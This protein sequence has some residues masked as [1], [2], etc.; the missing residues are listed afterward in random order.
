MSAALG[1]EFDKCVSTIVLLL[2]PCGGVKKSKKYKNNK[3]ARF[4]HAVTTKLLI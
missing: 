4:Q 2:F 1:Y 3:N